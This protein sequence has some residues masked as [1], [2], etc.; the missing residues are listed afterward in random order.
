MCESVRVRETERERV[1]VC[2]CVCK[3]ITKMKTWGVKL[4][5]N[6]N[7]FPLL[8]STVAHTVFLFGETF[9][10]FHGVFNII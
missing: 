1:C 10:V 4:L 8:L 3:A 5:A 6:N 7:N 9:I 2:V